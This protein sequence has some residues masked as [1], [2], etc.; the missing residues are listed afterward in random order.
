MPPLR[1][2]QPAVLQNLQQQIE[3]IRMGFLDFIEEHHRIG[4]A[5]DGFRQLSPFFIAHIPGRRTH[6]S[7][8]RV[9]FHIFRHIKPEHGG[10]VP[11]QHLCQRPAKLRFAHTGGAQKQEGADGAF[12]VFQPHA[13]PADGFRHGGDRFLLPHNPAM[14]P[15]FQMEQPLPLFFRQPGNRNPCPEGNHARHVLGGDFSL[16]LLG[17]I[18][19]ALLLL[20]QTAAKLLLF[21]S[22][23]SGAL[24]VLGIDGGGFFLF[25]LPHLLF[26]LP[27]AVRRG[28]CA[29]PHPGR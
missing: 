15:L 5:A 14:E 19:P 2:R 27:D 9:L 10:F 29:E 3:Y 20:F 7:G 13:A 18:L 22:Q 1:I 23:R 26:Q 12:R 21:V 16:L 8:N 17:F 28:I 6:Q 11:E 4:V 24:K 25:Q